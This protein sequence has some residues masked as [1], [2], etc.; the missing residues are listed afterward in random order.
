MPAKKGLFFQGK[1][2]AGANDGDRTRD[3]RYHKPALYQLS[4]VRHTARGRLEKCALS[5]NAKSDGQA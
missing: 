4:Y 3:N 2:I 1:Y 5:V